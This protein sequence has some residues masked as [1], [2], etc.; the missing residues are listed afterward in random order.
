MI[1]NRS[2]TNW[3]EPFLRSAGLSQEQL[4]EA[5]SMSRATI[6]RL[7]NDHSRLKL[8]RAEELA[9]HLGVPAEQLMLNR[10]P[11]GSGDARGPVGTPPSGRLPYA[12]TVAAG[13]WLSVDD[14]N[15]DL[16]DSTVPDS[17]PRHPRFSQLQQMAWRVRGSSMDQAGILDGMWLVGASYA[18]YVDKVGE[19]DNGFVVVVERSRFQGAERELTVK[20]V[21]FASRGM[22][23]IPRSSEARHKEFFVP[24][25]EEA[26]P[27]KE[28]IRILGVVL[29]VVR[30]LAPRAR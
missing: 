19:L 22:R 28:T 1:D 3:L 9:P 21:Q 26:D 5:I 8:D 17:V 10:P 14:F 11:Q 7:A 18:D 23:L 27:D 12:G 13:D 30:D 16:A 20:E 29:S 2:M 15:Q 24:L 4:A 6:N 25:D